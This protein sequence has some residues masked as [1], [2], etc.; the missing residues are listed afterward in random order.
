MK[1][2]VLLLPLLAMGLFSAFH[3]DSPEHLKMNLSEFGFFKGKLSDLTP[4]NDRVIPYKLNSPLF[5]DYAEKSRFVVFPEGSSVTFNPDSVL[6]FPIGTI[7][8]KT[9]YYSYDQRKP[10]K[11]R[12]LLETRLLV[13]EPTGW[14]NLPYVWEKDQSDAYLE[15]AGA[16]MVVDWV[17]EGGKKHT[18][19]YSSPNMNQCKGCHSR[20]NVVMPIGPSVRQLNGDY[21]YPDGR[22]QNQLARWTELGVLKGMPSSIISVPKIVDWHD[23]TQSLD[24]RA[25][26]YLDANCAHCHS[27]VGSASTSGLLLEWTNSDINKMGVNK[28][29]IAAGRGSGNLSYDIVPGHAEKSILYYRMASTDPGVMMP[30]LARKMVH[31]EGVQLIKEWIN[32]LK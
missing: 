29:P 3:N 20:N 21:T 12:R 13:N 22:T 26:S 16:N 19:D 32:Q 31:D 17:D 2:L 25:R 7:I 11:G 23:K 4:A 24:E 15:V 9:F 8:I 14:I 10:E 27:Q 1:K 28:A 6:Q 18:L 30:E 5:S